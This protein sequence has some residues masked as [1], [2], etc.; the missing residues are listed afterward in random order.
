LAPITDAIDSI[1]ITEPDERSAGAHEA[2][3]ERKSDA[4]SHASDRIP[5]DGEPYNRAIERS[6]LRLLA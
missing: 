6:K 4:P 5:G 1:E 2:R 3:K